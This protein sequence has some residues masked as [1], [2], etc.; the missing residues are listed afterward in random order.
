MLEFLTPDTFQALEHLA[1]FRKMTLGQVTRAVLEHPIG[2]ISASF[3]IFLNA[4][5]RRAG[6][7][8]M[9]HFIT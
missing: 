3:Q 5:K 2:H 4:L 9:L 7:L 1:R 6:M 8:R